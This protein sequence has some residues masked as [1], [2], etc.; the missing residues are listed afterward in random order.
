MAAGG[1][2]GDSGIVM[3]DACE[4]SIR[5][6]GWRLVLI[7]MRADILVCGVVVVAVGVMVLVVLGIVSFSEERCL[8][9]TE[10]EC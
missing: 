9:V 5:N 4:D 2:E 10:V 8:S 1:M 7:L 3:E 6:L